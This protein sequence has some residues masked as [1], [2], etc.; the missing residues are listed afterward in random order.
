MASSSVV[1]FLVA[2]HLSLVLAASLLLGLLSSSAVFLVHV[3]A[4]AVF[5]VA[6]VV[7][8]R[9]NIDDVT[10]FLQH[11][12]LIAGRI[13]EAV[14]LTYLTLVSA[15]HHTSLSVL[16]LL[17][18]LIDVAKL[19]P[20]GCRV[21]LPFLSD[22]KR[23]LYTG[24]SWG[25]NVHHAIIFSVHLAALLFKCIHTTTSRTITNV[26][27]S[28]QAFFILACKLLD[29]I[30]P[31]V[32]TFTAWSLPY[33]SWIFGFLWYIS[34]QISAFLSFAS[35][36]IKIVASPVFRV[37]FTVSRALAFVVV[38]IIINLSSFA[39]VSLLRSASNTN[40]PDDDARKTAAESSE[41]Q[42]PIQTS[43]PSTDTQPTPRHWV[44]KASVLP[45]AHTKIFAAVFLS[46]A[47]LSSVIFA[48]F[49]PGS[50][51][52]LSL[53]Q[54]NI[55]EATLN[56]QSHTL[57]VFHRM[58]FT[59][60]Q[61]F[62][63]ISQPEPVSS[64]ARQ[65]SPASAAHPDV[66]A[67]AD[68]LR[69]SF[70]RHH[71][72]RFQYSWQPAS[73]NIPQF[74]QSKA[75]REYAQCA[76]TYGPAF[77]TRLLLAN[78]AV[79]VHDPRA[80]HAMMVKD[81]HIWQKSVSPSTLLTVLLGPGVL[82]VRNGDVHRRQRK[83][84]NPVFSAA[85]LRDMTHIFYGV[86]HRLHTAL[87]E[88]VAASAPAQEVDMNDWMGRTTLEMLGQAG[89]G[90]SFD[91]FTDN[92]M[93]SF[94]EAIKLFFPS[95]IRA[96][97]IGLG[98]SSLSWYLSDPII[99][100]IF[101]HFP[102]GV[103]RKVLSISDIMTVRSEEI[104]KEKK[105]ALEKGDV[106]MK[107]RMVK[108]TDEE[109]VAQVSTFI[110]AGMDTT[111]N[112]LSRILHLLAM[113]PDVQDKL[114]AEIVEAQGG[115]GS[116]LAYDDLVKL[117]FL[118]AVCRETLRLHAP[119]AVLGRFATEDTVLPLS[120][121]VRTRDGRSLAELPVPRGTH[122]FMNFQACNVNKDLWGPDAREW[123]PERWLAPLPAALEDA[124]VPGVY[125]HLTT[126]AA[127][128]RSC[129][130]FKFSQLEMKI[131][132]CMLLS[133]FSFD[134]TEQPVSW[135]T[136]AVLYPSMGDSLKPELLLKLEMKI[137]LTKV[138]SSSTFELTEKPISWTMSAVVYPSMGDSLKPE[139]LLQINLALKA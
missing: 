50:V 104:I 136:S 11:S 100:A 106:A 93:D 72:D 109:I 70:R 48:S 39:L 12:L 51:T 32:L 124:R 139:M 138:L 117:P 131:V 41:R 40:S 52:T 98:A 90:Y 110:L 96:P 10:V 77:V 1:T 120:A 114:R 17:Q 97:L 91:D 107:H 69:D 15:I 25:T 42:D 64:F 89:L 66:F 44:D 22:V 30:L 75:W 3:L 119:V 49:V 45:S 87:M 37:L 133:S 86:S 33:L 68:F 36:Y 123:K 103:V 46:L 137:V 99:R 16:A 113:H 57:P 130:G 58:H 111:S 63:H 116:D 108:M 76:D 115:D 26:A 27:R 6:G 31:P 73:G 59:M 102:L 83:L 127:G 134:I 94:A 61:L 92:A 71:A 80:L 4:A 101:R 84:L 53:N 67:I 125:A 85:H 121:P 5:L 23:I 105:T 135:N 43:T 28:A 55:S 2:L 56:H 126:F 35:P 81:T 60:R 118:D 38:L 24:I 62:Q 7:V 13:L 9:V 34:R 112:A 128:P 54:G 19:N 78:R 129:I 122:V 132:L 82:S 29:T 79:V 20:T 8:G 21:L 65:N 88:R 95:L 14:A 18:R 47:I 74:F